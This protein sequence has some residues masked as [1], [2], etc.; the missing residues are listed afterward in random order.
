MERREKALAILQRYRPGRYTPLGAGF[1]GVVFHDGAWVYKVHVPISDRSYGEQ[2]HLPYLASKL[3]AFQ[4]ARHLYPLREL[5]RQDGTYI[6]VYPY[7]PTEPVAEATEAEWCSYLAETWERRIISRSV[8][9]STNFRRAAGVLKLIDYEIEPYDDNLFLNVAARAFIQ[10]PHVRARVSNLAKLRRSTINRFDLPELAGFFDFLAKV[11]DTI[12]ARMRQCAWDARRVA[13]PEADVSAENFDEVEALLRTRAAEVAVSLPLNGV[14][15]HLIAFAAL[16]L[17]YRLRTSRIQAPSAGAT[18]EEALRVRLEFAPLRDPA[19]PVTLLVKACPQD[20]EF[21]EH[22]VRHIVRG[23]SGPERFAERLLALDLTPRERFVRQF[24]NSTS[25][26][27]LIVGAGHLVEAGVIDRIVTSPSDEHEIRSLNRAWFGLDSP[28]THTVEGVPVIPQLH[29]FESVHT[30]AVLQV[31]IDALV[32]VRDPD[33]PVL[34]DMLRNFDDP[35]V[36]SVAF[37]ICRP[38]V[39]GFQPYF[40]FEDGGF[41]PEVRCCLLLRS[42]L[43]A[44]RPLPNDARTT[45]LGLGWYRSVEAR[46]RETGACSVRGGPSARFFIHPQNYRKAAPST[47]PALVDRVEKG[48]IPSH[49]DGQPEVRGAMADWNLPTRSEDLVVVVV[50]VHETPDQVCRLLLDL[51]VQSLP[52]LRSR[53]DRRHR[54]PARRLARR[55]TRVRHLASDRRRPPR[56]GREAG[57]C[58]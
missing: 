46:Q 34:A 9:L 13:V 55:R 17:G 48:A 50:I 35:R 2:D 52:Q 6:L 19:Q 16:R 18:V 39:E 14:D 53:P 29:A 24:T 32:G 44:L 27:S 45:G 28:H 58:S 31:D 36:V 25:W 1:A 57:R 33:H 37:P 41:V 11:G 47:W 51:E 4:G 10:L 15:P 12:G 3:D 5:A 20:A 7:E 22:A 54:Q 38:S 23:L 56:Q 26:D 8:N 42:R 40:G 30:D 43:L 21:L 49:Q